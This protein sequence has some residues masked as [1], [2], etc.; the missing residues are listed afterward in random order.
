MNEKGNNNSFNCPVVSGYSDVLRSAINPLK[1]FNIPLD[2]PVINFKEVK[3]LTRQC[4]DYLKELLGKNFS[5]KIFKS[6]FKEAVNAQ[7]DYFSLLQQKAEHLLSSAR[8]EGRMLILL[9]GRPYHTDPLIQH[10]VSDIITSFGVDVITEDIVRSDEVAAVSDVNVIPQWTYVNRIM[11]AAQWVAHSTDRV[12]YVQLTSFGCGPDAV[13]IDEVDDILRRAHKNMTIL[14]V[15][16]VNNAGSLRLRIRSLIESLKYSEQQAKAPKPFVTTPAY[17]VNDRHRTILIPYFSDFISPFIP[18]AF[19]LA[20]ERFE[21]MEPSDKRSAELG[22][23]YANNEICYPATLVVGDCIKALQSGKYNPDDIAFGIT[24]TGGQCR[25]TNYIALIKKAL[26]TAGYANVPVV[27][28][29]IMNTIND[30]PGFQPKISTAFAKM[31]VRVV[32]YTDAISQI[33]YACAVREKEPGVALRL[34]TK[35]LNRGVELIQEKKDSQLA[36][37]LA[38][39][40]ADFDANTV[41]KSVPRIGVVGE[42]FIKYNNFGQQYVV[43]SLVKHG[44]EPVVPALSEFFTQYFPNAKFNGKVNL[45]LNTLKDK[46]TRNFVLEPMLR[47]IGHKFDKAA[48]A[49]RYFVPNDSIYEGAKDASKIVNLAAQFGEGW[50]IPSEFASFAKRG[51]R[52]AV[53]LQP[54]GCIANHIISKGIEKRVKDL[55][56]NLNLLF[57]DFDGGVSEVNVQNRVQFIVRQ[58]ERSFQRDVEAGIVTL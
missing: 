5:S 57:L 55:Y 35:Y 9:A 36:N 16:D 1:K 19:K 23:K 47:S 45:E 29:S 22:L 43:D 38:A 28:L 3:L 48:T 31:A 49:F 14:K 13:V 11:K 17:T 21:N 34:R 53:S 6:A 27:S 10:K 52:A 42:I 32:Y 58:V 39:A 2:A 4:H 40:A 37:L 26:V 7:L 50:L 46:F 24:Q 20:G 30:Q 56:P 44:I 25:A 8:S 18:A 33:Y 15:D 54:F 51:I 12:Y 41:T